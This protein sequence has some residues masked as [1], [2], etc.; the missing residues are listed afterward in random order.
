[1]R[2][3]E[4]KARVHDTTALIEKLTARGIT[5]SSPLKQ[6]DVVFA[7]PGAID[8][9]PSENWLRIRTQDDTKH[10]FTLKRSVTGDLDSI[11]HETV[12]ESEDE[13]R[14]IIHYLG[15]ELYSDL[16]KVRRKGVLDDL[17]ICIDELPNLGTFIELEKLA[18]DDAKA[19]V[20]QNNLWSILETLGINRSDEETSGYDILMNR[21][22]AQTTQ[23]VSITSGE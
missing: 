17:E 3:I 4:V 22:L 2:E 18:P 1:M 20:I 15:Y 19:S 16:T 10:F 14:S 7:R 21:Y 9:D 5:L 6:H 11:E 13:T 23:Q 12:V 8:N